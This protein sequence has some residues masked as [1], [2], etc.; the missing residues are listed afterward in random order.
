MLRLLKFGLAIFCALL[1]CGPQP[2]RAEYAWSLCPNPGGFQALGQMGFNRQGEF[3]IAANDVVRTKPADVVISTD[4]GA[5]W[6]DYRQGLPTATDR[7]YPIILGITADGDGYWYLAMQFYGVFRRHRSEGAWKKVFDTAGTVSNVVAV[8][9]RKLF[10]C[11]ATGNSS[12]VMRSTNNGLSWT[13]CTSFQLNPNT[14]TSLAADHA[15]RLF[16]SG[17]AASGAVL[18]SSENQGVTWRKS[19]TGMSDTALFSNVAVSAN[20]TLLLSCADFADV[21][22]YSGVYRSADHGLTWARTHM[23]PC[24]HVAVMPDKSIYIIAGI[25]S[26]TEGRVFRSVDEG[27]NWS[28]Y[29]NGV[30]YDKTTIRS[31]AVSSWGTLF[32]GTTS[33]GLY[34][35]SQT[36][37]VALSGFGAE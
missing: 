34:R 30:P 25:G 20:D 7:G 4:K 9:P 14:R 29:D 24:T 17:M 35:M 11:N 16:V 26:F 10:V 32:V 31:L 3:V 1:A 22:V 27:Q 2:G 13:S 5:S 6:S 8:T 18:Y 21:D 19:F 15:G 28:I 12:A 37:P 23:G 36:V 33:L